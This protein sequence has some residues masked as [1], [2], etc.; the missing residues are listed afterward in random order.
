MMGFY[1]YFFRLMYFAMVL[2][3]QALCPT[4]PAPAEAWPVERSSEAEGPVAGARGRSEEKSL[5]GNVFYQSA[6]FLL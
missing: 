3:P 4:L 6:F 5:P 1:I 2:I